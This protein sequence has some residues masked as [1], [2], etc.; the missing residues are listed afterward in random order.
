MK[1]RHTAALRD[2]QDA[3]GDFTGLLKKGL[4][5]LLDVEEE[6]TALI[7][8]E[9]TDVDEDAVSC[10]LVEFATPVTLCERER[11]PAYN[12]APPS[13]RR[14]RTAKSTPR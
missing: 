5:E 1:K 3:D 9:P 7:A 6:E 2:E 14:I 11:R 13:T 4:V 8:M 12:S 10:P